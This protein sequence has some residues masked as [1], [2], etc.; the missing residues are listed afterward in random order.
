MVQ[1]DR[2]TKIKRTFDIEN[3]DFLLKH[4]AAR[5]F[6]NEILANEHGLAHSN[7]FARYL[8]HEWGFMREYNLEPTLVILASPSSLA[9]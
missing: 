5:R 6:F 8:E 1:I 7:D 2:T 3:A 4:Q 9:L